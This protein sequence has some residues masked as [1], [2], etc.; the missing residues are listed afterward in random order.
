MCYLGGQ[1]A[2]TCRVIAGRVGGVGE[3]GEGGGRGGAGARSVAA[4]QP[5]DHVE[6]AEG[7]DGG[8]DDGEG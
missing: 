7:E 1:Q 4:G 8:V 6:E 3:G 2:G 5:Q